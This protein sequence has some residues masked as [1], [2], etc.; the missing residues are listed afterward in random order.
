[1]YLIILLHAVTSIHVC[2][3]VVNSAEQLDSENNTYG[4]I[5]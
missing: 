2:C 1:M 4:E 5:P 3:I